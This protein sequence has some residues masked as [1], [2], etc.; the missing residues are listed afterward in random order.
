MNP[1]VWKIAFSCILLAMPARAV[2][3]IAAAKKSV[4][5]ISVTMQAP[6]YRV[7]WTPGSVGGGVGA[8]F[9][10]AGERV[11]TNAHVVSNARFITIE[12][13]DD[14]KKYI[15]TVQHVA[16]DCDLA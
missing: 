8:G 7:P 3:P 11:M 9:V 16:H 10:I 15:A 5:R 6:N 2:T 13:E 1:R 4:V 12:K 14:P